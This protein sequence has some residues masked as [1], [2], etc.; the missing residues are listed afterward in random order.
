MWA[1]LEELLKKEEEDL[2]AKAEPLIGY[3]CSYVPEEIIIASGAKPVR[4]CCGGDNYYTTIGETYL[5]ESICP[6][7]KIC[8]AYKVKPGDPYFKNLDG[9]IFV[10]TC[11][12]MRRVADTWKANFKIPVF[13]LGLPR[14]FSTEGYNYFEAEIILL[15][16]TLETWIGK[17]ITNEGLSHNIRLNNRVRKII[18]TLYDL[19]KTLCVEIKGSDFAR[20]LK[21]WCYLDKSSFLSLDAELI[22]DAKKVPFNQNQTRLLLTGSLVAFGD[23]DFLHLLEEAGCNVVIEDTCL[24]YR[25]FENLVDETKEPIQ[26][27]AERYYWQTPCGRA[28][29]WEKRLRNIRRLF[30]EFR[31]Q[32]ILHHT[33]KFCDSY[34]IEAYLL[35]KT[36]GKDIPVLVVDRDYSSDLDRLRTRIEAFNEVILWRT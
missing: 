20:V 21:A 25:F 23:E 34:G 26:A 14:V 16:E 7:A 22:E 32:G 8:V 18:L 24:G 33:L 1:G 12:A 29:E 30:Y 11:D 4:L 31:A 19:R 5:G 9:V 35:Q 28:R 15:K 36:L 2:S 10:H 13:E 3:F 17:R 27:L 6:F